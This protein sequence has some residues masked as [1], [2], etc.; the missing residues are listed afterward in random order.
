MSKEQDDR[1]DFLDYIDK[2]SE[3]DEE[4]VKKFY[5]EFYFDGL[6]NT[7]EDTH[8]I[9]SEEGK[10]EAR[11]NHNSMK[12]DMLFKAKQQGTYTS[13]S[14]SSSAQ[15]MEDASDEWEWQD[16]FKI[17]GFEGALKVITEQTIRDL[18]NKV[19][20]KEIVLARYYEKRDRLRRALN[21]EKR[22]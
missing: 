1:Y 15:F 16:A 22:K 21:R 13:L 9:T 6:S 4:Y 5:R 11:R 20:E 19:L 14:N 18:E 12:T 2:L 7:P 10:K 3:E 8:I 17:L